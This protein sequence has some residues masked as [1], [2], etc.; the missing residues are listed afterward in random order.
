MGF[1][2]KE[3]P[4]KGKKVNLRVS[5]IEYKKIKDLADKYANGNVSSW[6]RYAART[7]KPRKKDL[8]HIGDQRI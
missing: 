5:Y 3:I 6:M 1:A 4:F 7:H 8:T 2:A